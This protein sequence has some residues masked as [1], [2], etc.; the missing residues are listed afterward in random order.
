MLAILRSNGEFC[1][2]STSCTNPSP[3]S[4]ASGST[5]SRPSRLSFAGAVAGAF[6]FSAV[7]VFCRMRHAIAPTPP[8][9]TR[10]GIFGSPGK[11]AIAIS[12]P[13]ASSRGCALLNTCF[14]K[15]TP[16]LVSELVRVMI[17]PPEMEIISAGITVTR[18]SPMVRMV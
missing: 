3:T 2:P 8:P 15:S 5:F 6:V 12:T 9:N 11:A 4:T 16:S 14:W 7:A 13:E 10:K 18:P 17:K 1:P